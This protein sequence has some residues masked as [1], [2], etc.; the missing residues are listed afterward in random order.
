MSSTASSS[1]PGQEP[2]LTGITST[3]AGTRR[4]RPAAI[5]LSPRTIVSAFRKTIPAFRPPASPPPAW[6]RTTTPSRSRFTDNSD[7]GDLRL[8]YQ[9]NPSTSWFLRVSD[10]KEER[11]QL[12]RP[13][14]CRSTARPTAAS[15]CS[16]SRPSSA[17]HASSAQNKILDARVGISRTKAGKFSTS[18]GSTPF[19]IP[20]LPTTA[21]RCRRSALH[22]H[23]RLHRLR[24]SKH[25]PA[26]P[27]SRPARS[28]GQLH[29]GSRGQHSHEVRL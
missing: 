27:E 6:P 14:V 18:I 5:N 22:R 1:V 9:Q 2:A 12:A 16:I 23:Q 10:R 24:P 11:P 26:V 21:C 4:F 15:A 7:K 29:P 17:T 13:A 20:G 19:T 3:P 8:D 25:Q 28:Q